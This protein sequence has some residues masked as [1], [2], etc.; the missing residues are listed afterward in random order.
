MAFTVH[1]TDHD[2][3]RIAGLLAEVW[4]SGGSPYQ[5]AV[6]GRVNP[7]GEEGTILQNDEAC[8]HLAGL[9]ARL[10][11]EGE[12]LSHDLSSAQWLYLLRRIPVEQVA[13]KHLTTGPNRLAAAEVLSG[14]SAKTVDLLQNSDLVSFEITTDTIQVLVRLLT[15]ASVAVT[16]QAMYR[17]CAKGA[18]LRLSGGGQHTVLTGEDI[19]R[20]SELYD[21]RIGAP[22]A[23][24]TVFTQT[25]AR[26]MVRAGNVTRDDIVLG[27]TRLHRQDRLDLDA[28]LVREPLRLPPM[29]TNVTVDTYFGPLLLQL[30]ALRDFQERTP[31]GETWWGVELSALLACMRAAITTLESHVSVLR[32]GY[33]LYERRT[34]IENF[35][36]SFQEIAAVSN[37]DGALRALFGL[38]G[39]LWPLIPGPVIRVAGNS[40][41]VDLV[42]ATSNLQRLT[43]I[44]RRGG[45]LANVRADRF[46]HDVQDVID[47][48]PWRP[49][50]ALRS[51]R[52][53]SLRLRG[54]PVT[55]LDAVGER[56]GVLLAISAKSVPYTPE[57]DMGEHAAVRNLA[58]RCERFVAEWDKRIETLASDRLG[59]NYDLSA[60]RELLGVVC[61][62]FAPYCHIGGATREIRPGLRAV[63]SLPEMAEWL[64]KP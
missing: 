31:E 62:P 14:R 46:E 61:L 34:F 18:S 50:P 21:S 13:G 47:V 56:D 27:A 48:S 55:D 36:A 41:Y 51:L 16:Y 60:Y 63:C 7:L 39:S 28:D 20:A 17:M 4:S 26:L 19:A 5:T 64:A 35:D 32:Y 45:K 49:G 6:M 54:R 1:L 52:G 33:A 59:Q 23:E 8:A 38:S 25:G 37:P 10:E 30:R 43:T 42:S 24:E 57:Y 15:T 58:D 9:I 12:E 2:E 53:R 11:R 3:K 40:L 29:V 22:T 44:A